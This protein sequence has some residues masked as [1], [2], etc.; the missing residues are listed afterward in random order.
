MSGAAL[1]N[2]V[3]E[4]CAVA[5]EKRGAVTW[6]EKIKIA[7]RRAALKPAAFNIINRKA[8]TCRYY[9]N[10]QYIMTSLALRKPSSCA[11]HGG[12]KP[13]VISIKHQT[14]RRPEDLVESGG[15]KYCA[16]LA[17]ATGWLVFLISVWQSSGGSESLAK[18]VIFS[19]KIISESNKGAKQSESLWHD[20]ERRLMAS[21]CLKRDVLQARW[22]CHIRLSL[23]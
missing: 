1:I 18:S 3:E 12:S 19:L 20:K 9:L 6:G 23:K 11:A 7:S 14:R 21:S 13:H 5:F 10:Y 4:K 8:R 2:K 16:K 17:Q 15:I 22:Q